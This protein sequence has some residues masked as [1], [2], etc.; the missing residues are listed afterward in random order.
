LLY[1]LLLKSIVPQQNGGFKADLEQRV[2]TIL[3]T[4]KMGI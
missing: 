4:L 1:Q 3:K 2:A